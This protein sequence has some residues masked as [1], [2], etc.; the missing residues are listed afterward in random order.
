MWDPTTLFW[1]ES[2]KPSVYICNFLDTLPYLYTNW[3]IHHKPEV[4]YDYYKQE[5]LRYQSDTI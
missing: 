3:L 2:S 1:K 5:E 4:Y